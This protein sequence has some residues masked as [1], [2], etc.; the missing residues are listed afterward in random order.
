[1]SIIN[2][3]YT[4]IIYPPQLFIEIVFELFYKVFKNSG[5]SVLGV[6]LAVSFICL[7]LYI[8]T[9][10]WQDTERNIQKRLAPKI[11]KIKAAYNGDER[12][13]ILSTFYK[14][15]N[16]HPFYAL[17]SSLGFLFQIPFFIAAYSY[18]TNLEIL[19]GVSFFFIRDLGASD[20]FGE[21]GIYS[22]NILPIIMTIINI[23]SG[24][25]YSIGFPLKEKMRIFIISV[26]FLLLL[27]NSP[28]ALVIYWTMNNIFSLIKNIFYKLKNPIKALY[29]ISVPIIFIFIFYMIFI[30]DGVLN[31]RLFVITAAFFILLAPFIVKYLIN[32]YRNYLL[33]LTENPHKSNILFISFSLALVILAGLFIPSSIISTS[34]DEFCFIGSINTPL[35]Y[36]AHSFLIY[37]GIFFFWPICIF[38]LFGKKIKSFLTAAFG[39][40]L[41]IALINSFAFHGNYGIITNLFQFENTAAL[42]L[43][44]YFY[45]FNIL[46]LLI[47]IFVF[48]F[49]I[50]KHLL[51]Q[52]TY[53]SLI[54]I[55]SLSLSSVY[56]IFIIQKGFINLKYKMEKED[57]VHT[58]EK[59]FS[60]SKD[61]PN[62]IIFMADR[63][64]SS[65]LQPIFES[66]PELYDDFEGF[67]YYPNTLSFARSTIMGVPAIWGGFEYTPM[68]MNKRDMVSLREKHN[69]ALLLLPVLLSEKNFDITVTDSS[70]ANYDWYPDLS[71]YDGLKNV[72]AFITKGRYTSYWLKNNNFGNKEIISETIKRNCV[73]FTLFQIT[74][75]PLRF[76][77]YDNGRYLSAATQQN[78]IN[79]FIDNYAFIDYLPELTSFNAVKSQAILITNETTHQQRFLQYPDYIPV[80]EVTNYGPGP[81]NG[82]N[83]Y[84]TNAAMIIRFSKWLKE[85]KKEGVYDNTRIIIVADHGK[86]EKLFIEDN[87]LLFPSE[88]MEGYNPLLMVKDFN[89]R[90]KLIINNAFMTNA[91]VPVLALN[92]IINNPINPFTGNI[93][94]S[95]YKKD[96]IYITTNHD[97]MPGNHSKNTYNIKKNQW[98]FVKD[99]I[100][101]P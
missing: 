67:T 81:L 4:I 13:M 7:P 85:L 21:I 75:P 66:R 71:I 2:I 53:M 17:R 61:K 35:A 63:G 52:L 57:T 58:L 50:K 30:N 70:F 56:Y 42:R 46:F 96:G 11:K 26:V 32:F 76:I 14:Q 36:L 91:D 22:I 62:L 37:L 41:F 3:L 82:K 80:P 34:P 38:Y 99:S 43:S 97:S 47:S 8:V 12:Y 15:N 33:V 77:I 73:F 23:T 5:I 95:K 40:L 94:S 27:Y 39:I 45:F 49:L 93:L 87:Y 10:K 25:F 92:G 6:S 59:I 55:I 83:I 89:S 101:E 69:R 48:V 24:I 86:N 44:T 51:R 64:I 1:M 100:F 16:Y 60:L 72:K 9:E 19:K 68:E 74:P 54:I 18:L 79:V 84:H 90:G 78:S 31:K 28:A 20:A 65:F 29:I 98:L 88:R